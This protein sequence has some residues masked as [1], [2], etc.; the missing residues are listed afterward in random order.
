MQNDTIDDFI[1]ETMGLLSGSYMNCLAFHIGEI[2]LFFLDFIE[3]HKMDKK[4]QPIVSSVMEILTYIFSRVASP[5][6]VQKYINL[7]S[8]V[9]GK[10][11]PVYYK[12]FAETLINIVAM[13]TKM[14]RRLYEDLVAKRPALDVARPD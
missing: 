10:V 12:T 6:T 3:S 13:N 9:E 5:I 11:L 2:D 1:H 4:K 8:P 7:L 14:R